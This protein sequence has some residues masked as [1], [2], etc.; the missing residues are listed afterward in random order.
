MGNVTN[1]TSC[2]VQD[3]MTCCGKP[4]EGNEIVR[5]QPVGFPGFPGLLTSDK[6]ANQ[7]EEPQESSCYQVPESPPDKTEED[8]EETYD[9]G[10]TYVGQIVS[11]QRHGHG[12][13]TSADEQYSGQ[14]KHGHR[15][16]QGRQTWQ[17]GRVFEGQFR[18]GKLEGRGR[19]EWHMPKG[20]LV[21]EGEYVNDL[22]EGQGK[23]IWPDGRMY[24]GEWYQG[25]R[26]G[27][28][29]FV[30]SAGERRESIWNDDKLERWCDQDE[31]QA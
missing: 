21:Y 25:K 5:A 16:G 18:E 9:D 10:S 24:D 15:D 29:T 27:K 4:G 22:K 6:L 7:K 3:E 1:G 20:L 11:G 23:Y 28:A 8:V 12:V 19:M 26:S 31:G 17:D 2:C 30:N 14:W 13:R